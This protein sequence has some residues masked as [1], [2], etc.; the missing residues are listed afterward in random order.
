MSGKPY[1]AP[2]PGPPPNDGSQASEDQEEDVENETEASHTRLISDIKDY[3]L[4]HGHLLKVVRFE[5]PS[6]VPAVGVNVSC[7]P[8]PFPRRL[9]QHAMDLQPAMNEL[10]IRAA[11][12]DEWLHSVLRPQI[13]GEPDGLVASLWDVWVKCREVGVVQ[14]EVTLRQVEMN[15][16]S[17][18]G[19]CH[20]EGVAGMHRWLMQREAAEMDDIKPLP[21]LGDL[22]ADTNTSAIV[23]GLSTAHKL[24]QSQHPN[25]HSKCILMVVQPL[26]F[27]IADERPIEYGLFACYRCE[28]RDVLNRCHVGPSRELL[29]QPPA[30][31]KR[32]A[33]KMFEVSV[34][35]YRAGYDME[36]YNSD[37]VKT[38][39]MLELSRAIKCPG[40][41]MHMVGM[42]SVQR[43]LA[44]P[45]VVERFLPEARQAGEVQR[46]FLPMLPLDSS[47]QGLEARRLALDPETAVDYVLKPNLE[48]GGHNV[49]RADIPAYLSGIP[50]E[51]WE[52]YILM[53]L[54]TPPTNAEP[55]IL[56]TSEEVYEG[57]VVSELGVLGFAMWRSM[58][59]GNGRKD[60]GGEVEILENEA[61][62]WT[63]KTKPRSVDEMS[64]VKGY[65]CFD[66]PLLT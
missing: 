54:I 25:D 49:F 1:Y 66:C 13:E 9:F 28:W 53:R 60:G 21:H 55:G 36:E 56:L 37:G 17:V 58:T 7:R 44:E 2:P 50:E 46:T 62:G 63:F 11:S 8:T 33:S 3:L 18:A 12:D 23:S 4:T 27:N 14:E 34:V 24:Y 31:G 32:K 15:T 57:P 35:Y 65:G 5:T 39:S 51:E 26:N 45:G 6:R 10:Y 40:V 16:F 59:P 29:Y 19:A 43:A 20:A 30:S 38:R 52:R 42:K 61:V 64:V 41:K 48:G 22:P 47:R